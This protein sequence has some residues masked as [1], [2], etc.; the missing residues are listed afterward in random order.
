MNFLNK[1]LPLFPLLVV[2]SESASQCTNADFESG[3]FSGWQ[4]RTGTC[5][6]INLP[7]AGIVGGRHTIT[8]GTATDPRT[9]NQ[10]P[11]VSP[12][13]GNFSARLGNPNRGSRAESLSYTYTV[14]PSSTLF[15]YQY[16]VVFE[17]PGHNDPDQPRFETAVIANGQ[18][19]PCT[20][21]MVTAAS[22]LPGFQ[23]CPGLDWQGNPINIAY[24]NWSTVGVDL[25]PYIGQSITLTFSTGDCA[26]G[27]HYGYAYI[28]AIGCQPMELE[29]QYCVGDTAAVLSAPPG[30]S[31][32]QWSTGETSQSITVDPS[33][34]SQASCVL[35]SFSG[36]VATLTT[37]ILPADPQMS[38]TTTDPCE[39]SQPVLTNLTTSVH[40]PI[41]SWSWN[42]GDG[43]TSNLQNPQHSYASPGTYAVS[44]TA[45]TE[46]GCTDTVIDT[47]TIHPNPT[48]SVN[49][50]QICPGE[51]AVLIASGAL[52][53]TWTP[54]N[55]LNTTVGSSVIS[56]PPSTTT[57]TVTGTDQYGCVDTATGTVTVNNPP[58]SPGTISHN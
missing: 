10:V 9:C 51:S 54:P 43:T 7:N 44:L 18:I 6:P 14:T 8:S 11:V 17:D 55:W 35:T 21:Y 16:A 34:V 4:G 25:T 24:R 12:N 45:V 41:V 37:N 23:T 53:Y 36:C 31:S 40:S 49:S 38:L 20:Y 1:L 19:I 48:V 22:N 50:P 27:A 15:T 58:A 42:F 52:S 30:F 57:Y 2:F 5:C 26:L 32:Y 28:D 13:G 56:T 33:I 29:V 46:L 47:L 3:T 39:G